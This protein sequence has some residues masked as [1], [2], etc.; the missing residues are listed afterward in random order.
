MHPPSAAGAPTPTLRALVDSLG[1]RYVVVAAH[2]PR[3]GRRR[4]LLR[5][6]VAM[7][8]GD[9]RSRGPAGRRRRQRRGRR[10]GR[11]STPGSSWSPSAPSLEPEPGGFGRL[12]APLVTWR[13][14]PHDGPAVPTARPDPDRNHPETS[15]LFVA[16]IKSQIKRIRT[17]EAARLRNKSVQVARS[18]RPSAVPRGRRRRRPRRGAAPRCAR[19]APA[20]Q[21]REQGRHPRQPGRQQEVGDGARAPTRSEPTRS[22]LPRRAPARAR[23]GPS[24]AAR[25]QRCRCCRAA[26]ACAPPLQRVGRV[27]RLALHV[28]VQRRPPPPAPGAARLGPAAALARR[29]L[30]LPRRHAEPAGQLVL[31]CPRPAERAPGRPCAR[32]RPARRR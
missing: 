11:T 5:R 17:N 15:R 4:R 32:R 1:G 30:D 22:H 29:P 2:R 10:C 25:C 21:G 27:G 19:L 12:P 14:C 18:R 8:Y 13:G 16:N 9:R 20:G 28:G 23:H 6:R 24:R 3:A 31:V 26:P 7:V